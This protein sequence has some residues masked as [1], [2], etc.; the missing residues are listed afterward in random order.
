[1][2]GDGEGIKPSPAPRFATCLAE[3]CDTRLA[4]TPR[5]RTACQLRSAVRSHAWRST[6]PRHAPSERG[7]TQVFRLKQQ[8][9]PTLVKQAY[10]PS[11]CGLGRWRRARGTRLPIHDEHASFRFDTRGKPRSVAAPR[12]KSKSL[13]NTLSAAARTR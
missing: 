9:A 4:R 3:R 11:L 5:S 7:N 10:L 1:M 13:G 6:S 12:C 2:T 8:T